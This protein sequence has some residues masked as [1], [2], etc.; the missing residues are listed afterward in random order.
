MESAK[1]GFGADGMALTTA[2]QAL[3]LPVPALVPVHV[4]QRRED[5]RR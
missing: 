2:G 4:L 3:R 5:I 1:N